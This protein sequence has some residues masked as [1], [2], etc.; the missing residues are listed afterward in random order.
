MLT[1]LIDLPGGSFRMGST[2]FY[3]DE[4]PVHSV[5]VGPF[6]TNSPQAVKT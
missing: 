5:T 3:P 6:V 1:E 2:S 4:G